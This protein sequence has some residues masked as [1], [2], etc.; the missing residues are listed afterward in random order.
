M[1]IYVFCIVWE[2]HHYTHSSSLQN[3]NYANGLNNTISEISQL[4]ATWKQ[5]FV[6]MD[7][8]LERVVGRRK[9]S[10]SMKTYLQSLETK[11]KNL[12]YGE[13]VM[14]NTFYSYIFVVCVGGKRVDNSTVVVKTRQ[15]P[16]LREDML[17]FSLSS[18][19]FY[20]ILALIPYFL[21]GFCWSFQKKKKTAFFQ[22]LLV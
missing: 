10:T 13:V 21:G 5:Q 8:T 1:F 19:S 20:P 22:K 6:E 18:S 16:G 7:F 17:F 4:W 9:R 15:N 14:F 12:V 2:S 11:V 3:I